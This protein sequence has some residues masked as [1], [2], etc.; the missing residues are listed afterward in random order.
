ML[1]LSR[2]KDGAEK[3]MTE[4]SCKK[5]I[6]KNPKEFEKNFQELLAVKKPEERIYSSLDERYLRKAIRLFKFGQ[7]DA[8][9]C[10]EKQRNEFYMDIFN[11]WVSMLSNPTCRKGTLF[12]ADCDSDEDEDMVRADIATGNVICIHEYATKNGRHF[13]LNPFNPNNVPYEVKK[14]ALLLL[15]F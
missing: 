2:K 1:L 14:N 12:L 7:L 8:D 15:A 10:G 11:R 3:N 5:L 9:Y 4:H 6:S 13:I